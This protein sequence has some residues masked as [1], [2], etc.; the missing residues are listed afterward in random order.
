M[1]GELYM[2]GD[3]EDEWNKDEKPVDQKIE[4]A[5]VEAAATSNTDAEPVK[6]ANAPVVAVVDVK[7]DADR[8]ADEDAKAF[9]DAWAGTPDSKEIPEIAPEIE[10]EPAPEKAAAPTDFKSAFAA[11]RAD[12]KKD[13]PWNGKKYTTNLASDKKAKAEHVTLPDVT[14]TGKKEP[15]AAKPGLPNADGMD[16]SQKRPGIMERMR[17]NDKQLM[18]R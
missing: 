12:G 4:P 15:A 14:V 5:V 18:G 16:L 1:N 10:A 8:A 6:A 13:F 3:Y 7:A 17:A 9:G 11:A 2:S